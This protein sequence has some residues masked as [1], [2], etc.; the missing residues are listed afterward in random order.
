VSCARRALAY[1][2]VAGIGMHA[3]VQSAQVLHCRLHDAAPVA[4]RANA[5][6]HPSLC[7]STKP[8]APEGRFLIS[9]LPAAGCMLQL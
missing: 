3:T 1:L 4:A 6:L 7:N 8:H 5:E 2:Q 9:K